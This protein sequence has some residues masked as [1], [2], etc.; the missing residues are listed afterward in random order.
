MLVIDPE[1]K[2][3]LAAIPKL[4]VAPGKQE[5][6]TSPALDYWIEFTVKVKPASNLNAQTAETR[7]V[8]HHSGEI[9]GDQR[10]VVTL[11]PRNV[12]R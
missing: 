11:L 1:S 12:R 2:K 9:F 5:R 3:V 4:V 7:V 10:S 8:V 6:A